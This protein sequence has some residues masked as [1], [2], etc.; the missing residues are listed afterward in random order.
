MEK[1]YLETSD[2]LPSFSSLSPWE[3][4]G[5]LEMGKGG[6]SEGV[7]VCLSRALRDDLGLLVRQRSGRV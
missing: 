1:I 5:V 2:F 6:T 4:Q 3:S 7:W